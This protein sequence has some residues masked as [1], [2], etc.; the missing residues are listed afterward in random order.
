MIF[1]KELNT[2]FHKPHKDLCD[3]CFTFQH[4]SAEDRDKQKEE[5]EERL[6]RNSKFSNKT[7]YDL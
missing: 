7:C 2:S 1:N 6:K 4:L 3:K 5:H